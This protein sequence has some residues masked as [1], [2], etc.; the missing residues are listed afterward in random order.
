MIDLW[1]GFWFRAGTWTAEVGISVIVI[2][3]FV[4]IFFVREVVVRWWEKSG[5]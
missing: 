3:L 5:R 4:A 1:D 2:A